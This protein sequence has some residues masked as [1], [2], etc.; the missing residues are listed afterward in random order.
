MWSPKVSL[1]T[2]WDLIVA[3]DNPTTK[4]NAARTAVAGVTSWYVATL[5]QLPEAYWA[6]VSTLIVMQSTLGATLPVSVQRFAGTAVGATVGAA[7]SGL[8]PG[9]IALFAL[10]LWAVGLLA[11]ALRIDR[12]AYRY[13]G[14]TLAIVMIVP[15]S[16]SPWLIA[17]HRFCEVS[18]GIA[19]S[20]IVSALWPERATHRSTGPVGSE[21]PTS[22]PG[23]SRP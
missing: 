21:A 3:K 13:A 20:L 12:S 6:V 11:S 4:Q 22:L 9:S 7:T 8:F 23:A 15:R 1:V 16:A 14:V 18:I 5:V 2:A 19:V 17:M 10:D